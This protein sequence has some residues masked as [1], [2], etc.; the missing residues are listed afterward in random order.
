MLYYVEL[1]VIR[2]SVIDSFL[3]AKLTVINQVWGV[4]LL[5]SVALRGRTD[6]WNVRE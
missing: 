2:S 3:P 4:M 1:A 6:R 5:L